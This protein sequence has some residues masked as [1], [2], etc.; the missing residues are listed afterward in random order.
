ML[1]LYKNH[2]KT[3]KNLKIKF[4]V[5]KLQACPKGKQNADWKLFI[6]IQKYIKLVCYKTIKQASI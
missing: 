5:K 4:Q 6:P 3:C 1:N 2:I